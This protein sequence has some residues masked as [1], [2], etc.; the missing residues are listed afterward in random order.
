MIII[1]EKSSSE[2]D[3]I[4]ILSFLSFE[5]GGAKMFE[6]RWPRDTLYTIG[7]STVSPITP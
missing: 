6:K 4:L 2:S 5:C 7:A 1:E 3:E